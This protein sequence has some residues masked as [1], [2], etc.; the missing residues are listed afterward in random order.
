MHLP[1]HEELTFAIGDI[2]GCF[3]KLTSLLVA[4][5]QIRGPRS[6][7][8]VLVGDYID[9]GPQSREVMDFLVGSHG[10]QNR[11]FVCLR[12]N[13]EEMLLRAADMERTDRDL[14]NWWGNGGEQT[15]DSY[16]IDDPADL[17]SEHLDWIRA[18]QLTKIEHGRLFVHAGLRPDVPLT[19]QSERDLLWIREP[20]LS[21]DHDHGLFVVHGHTPV[22]TGTPD[23]R[24][25]RLNLDTGA[26]FGGPLTAA[27]F[28]TSETGPLMFVTDSGEISGP[29]ALRD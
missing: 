9:R 14:M 15:L 7:Q 20:F 19:S 28:A 10:K 16:G 29:A 13:H 27:V 6:A 26:C 21:S 17:P 12:G 1:E 18:L 22:R 24:A 8:F 4:C 23:L 3:E 5:D 11:P 2:H 25:N